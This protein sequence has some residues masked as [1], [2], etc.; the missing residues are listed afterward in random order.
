MR[1]ERKVIWSDVDGVVCD[2]YG[3]LCSF[4]GIEP[5]RN[6]YDAWKA[7]GFARKEDFDPILRA[8]HDGGF[9]E[10]APEME[11]AGPEVY[12]EARKWG[13][14][15]NF[16]TA[17]PAWNHPKMVGE[18]RRWLNRHGYPYEMLVFSPYKAGVVQ[19]GV[20]IDDDLG[21]VQAVA[22]GG[23]FGVLIDRPYN[24]GEPHDGVL[25]VPNLEQA[26]EV[27]LYLTGH[28]RH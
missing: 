25:R 12:Y 5:D 4:A 14:E 22:K 10:D 8:F 17:R 26:M 27:A 15:V 1:D 23:G 2:Y 20:L 6:H 7:G 19:D 13:A 21:H 16:L 18:T 9:Q 3:R 11:G 24:R 28:K